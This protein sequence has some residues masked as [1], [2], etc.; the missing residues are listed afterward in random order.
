MSNI[1]PHASVLALGEVL[2]STSTMVTEI[3]HYK[4]AIAELEVQRA[5]MHQQAKVMIEQIDLNHKQEIKKIDALS[6]AFK[7]CLKQN[8]ILIKQQNAQQK[9]T[10]QQCMMLLKMVSKEKDHAQKTLL[11]SLWQEMLKQIELNREET[12]RLQRVLMDAHHQ[13]GIDLSSS[14][15]NLKDVF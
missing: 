3:V 14:Q 7:N 2:T 13:L 10:Q 4:R 11:M 15:L 1:I 9:F 6:S 5:H 8:K 12:A